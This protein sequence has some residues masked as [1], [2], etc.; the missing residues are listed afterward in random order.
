M[1]KKNRFEEARNQSG[2]TYQELADKTGLAKSTIYRYCQ[3]NP[4][5]E[6]AYV[7]SAL[8]EVLNLEN[9]NLK[10]EESNAIVTVVDALAEVHALDIERL[11]AEHETEKEYLREQKRKSDR[12][13]NILF[14][15]IVALFV[16]D[17]LIPSKGWI[18]YVSTVFYSSTS[19]FN[20]FLST[21]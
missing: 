17:F 2:L 3:G 10:L 20:N 11:Q 15:L 7:V 14:C 13:R 8:N 9:E 19:L 1:E 6:N 21:I 18:Q 5:T 16:V 12:E 4:K